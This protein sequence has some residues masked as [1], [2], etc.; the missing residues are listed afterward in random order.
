[1]SSFSLDEKLSKF[2]NPISHSQCTS[3]HTFALGDVTGHHSAI[4][5]ELTI[6]DDQKNETIKSSCDRARKESGESTSPN[7]ER[8]R[9]KGEENVPPTNNLSRKIVNDFKE[10]NYYSEIPSTIVTGK[11]V[12]ATGKDVAGASGEQSASAYADVTTTKQSINKMSQGQ[13][14][15]DKTSVPSE[16][17]LYDKPV[18]FDYVKDE[19]LIITSN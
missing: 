1:M 5:L 19:V 13:E 4:S 12:I 16:E 2:C 18:S 11:K 15:Q 9:N 10:E 3:K 8:S 14:S 7:D 6:N 17:A